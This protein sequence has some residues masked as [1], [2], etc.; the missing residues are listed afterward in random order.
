MT[1]DDIRSQRFSTRLLQGLSPE[2]VSAFLEDVAEAFATVQD[3]NAALT[4]RVKA[5]EE[6]LRTRPGPEALRTT[7][8]REVEALLRDAHAQVE[9]LVDGARAREVELLRDAET[10]KARTQAE[11]EDVM[12]A[13]RASADALVAAAREQEAAVRGE[14]DRLNDSRLRLIDEVRAILDTYQQ[15]LG[16]VDPRGR[17]RGRWEAPDMPEG[18]GNGVGAAEESRAG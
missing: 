16:T 4:A 3:A 7:V 12:A 14:I 13:A 6:E 10:V 17:A 18:L 1:P 2:E 15:W 9:T 8:L 11:A 5:L